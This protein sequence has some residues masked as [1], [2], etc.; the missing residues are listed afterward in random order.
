MISSISGAPSYQPSITEGKKPERAEAVSIPTVSEETRGAKAPDDSVSITAEEPAKEPEAGKKK[1]G[2]KIKGKLSEV[3]E[4]LSE[5]KGKIP[6]IVDNAIEGYFTIEESMECFP[7]FIYPAV[8][9]GSAD[10]I[11]FTY[12]V[13]DK[14][15]MKDVTAS[16]NIEWVP[17]LFMSADKTAHASGVAYANVSPYIKI[18]RDECGDLGSW[19]EK[20]ITHEVGHT[21]D[22]SEGFFSILSTETSNS[23]IWGHG[24]RI[25]E[26]AKT[27]EREDFAESFMTYYSDPEKLKA[28]CPEKYERIKE[29]EETG[30]FEGI[31]EKD[32]FRET[33]KWIGQK[34]SEMPYLQTAIE[35]AS[36]VIGAITLVTDTAA[37]I[38]G[39]KTGDE[40]SQ[41]HGAMGATATVLS[42]AGLPIAGAAV[43]GA[44]K[45]LGRAVKKGEI[46]AEEA[47]YVSS[48]TVGAPLTGLVKAGKWVHSKVFGNKPGK[49][50]EE[51]KDASAETGASEGAKAPAEA[52]APVEAKA[53][54]VV[55]GEAE[56]A[57]ETA[58]TVASEE[59]KPKEKATLKSSA[60]A[61]AIGAGGAVGSV[62][63]SIGGIYAGVTAGFAIGG[64]VGGA[65]GFVAGT[66]LGNAIMN[67][68]GAKIGA[69]I[70]DKIKGVHKKDEAAQAEISQDPIMAGE[71]KKAPESEKA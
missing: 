33:G 63:G 23:D 24:E 48:H 17:E 9:G 59:A 49:E 34:M 38:H 4:K 27:N 53:T 47:N 36:D 28:K 67:R 15:P 22:Y 41:M 25:T 21:R 58:E 62:A 26:Y 44:R 71:D 57:V 35:T 6:E 56:E 32:A 13:L 42:F 31:V 68:I 10:E 64:P 14:L 46:T 18:A 8:T 65:I 5:A 29:L 61:F 12:K 19:A 54:A 43:D 55:A 37:L 30:A 20:V 2:A 39:V 3:K 52:G 16:S 70:V 69:A 66:V 1:L 50:G 45:A 11:A 40:E 7:A 60:K 51:I